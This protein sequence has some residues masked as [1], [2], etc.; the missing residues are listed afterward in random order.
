M[1][2]RERLDQIGRLVGLRPSLE[3]RE[4][5]KHPRHWSDRPIPPWIF[6]AFL[7]LIITGFAL[8]TQGMR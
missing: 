8:A 3:E 1:T 2:G 7:A 5:R 4:L 6:V